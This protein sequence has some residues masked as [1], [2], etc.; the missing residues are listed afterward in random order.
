MNEEEGQRLL[1]QLGIPP[2]EREGKTFGFRRLPR[3]T[4]QMLTRHFISKVQ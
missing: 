3:R 1:E 2:S 4:R